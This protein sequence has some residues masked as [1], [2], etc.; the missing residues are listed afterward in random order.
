MNGVL[1]TM[2]AHRASAIVVNETE[3]AYKCSEEGSWREF[4]AGPSPMTLAED[5][6]SSACEPVKYQ[7]CARCGH[8]MLASRPV[9]E[10]MP[11]MLGALR[12]LWK[13][14]T[15]VATLA[16]IQAAWLA[17]LPKPLIGIHIRARTSTVTMIGR[18]GT[19]TG[20]GSRVGCRAC[21]RC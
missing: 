10:T 1:L 14:E 15:S 3:W 17:S 13:L 9:E 4:F 2:A 20:T 8:D 21:R 6:H 19:R 5:P 11:L 18:G 16:E 7:N 12:R